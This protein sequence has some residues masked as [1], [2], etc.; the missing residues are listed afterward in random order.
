[1]MSSIVLNSIL[2]CGQANL[3]LNPTNIE[4][5]VSEVIAKPL[6]L[7]DVLYPRDFIAKS[8]CPVSRDSVSYCFVIIY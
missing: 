4:S 8:N 6:L 1:M 2:L 3:T 5:V 7:T